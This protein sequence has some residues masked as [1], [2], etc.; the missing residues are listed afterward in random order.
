VRG[1]VLGKDGYIE[2][3]TSLAGYVKTAHHGLVIYVFL[4]NGWE[5]GLD[6]IWASEDGFL[7]RLARY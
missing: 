4:V 6:A 5:N 7:S 3:V 2:G 1:R